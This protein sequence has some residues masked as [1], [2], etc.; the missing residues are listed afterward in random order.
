MSITLL[1]ALHTREEDALDWTVVATSLATGMGA[2]LMRKVQVA[3]HHC[4]NPA[5]AAQ[6]LKHTWPSAAV[7]IRWGR[8]AT[9]GYAFGE[10]FDWWCEAVR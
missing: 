1:A 2:A 8:Q 7:L 3:L 5:A 4:D 9:L 10:G 6:V